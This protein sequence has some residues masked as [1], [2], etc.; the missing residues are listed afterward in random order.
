[1]VDVFVCNYIT[2]SRKVRIYLYIHAKIVT[3]CLP[4]TNHLSM[5]CHCSIASNF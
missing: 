2:M 1:M 4:W 5:L 3:E